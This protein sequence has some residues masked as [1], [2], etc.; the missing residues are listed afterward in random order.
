MPKSSPRTSATLARR[1]APDLDAEPAES[2]A[3]ELARRL[4]EA[5]AVEAEHRTLSQQRAGEQDR[6]RE[7]ETE[8][9]TATLRLETLCREAGVATTI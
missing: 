5:R 4:R 6:L 2:Q 7:A 1:M 3:R 8:R 9:D